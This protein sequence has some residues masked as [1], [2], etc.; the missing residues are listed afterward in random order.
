[1]HLTFDEHILPILES[2]TGLAWVNPLA[3]AGH[4]PG[5]ILIIVL[6]YTFVN[7]NY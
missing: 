2:S 7:N 3:W 1:M 6:P 4:G 5:T